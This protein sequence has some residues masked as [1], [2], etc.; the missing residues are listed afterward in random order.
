MYRRGVLS[1]VLHGI[2]RTCIYNLYHKDCSRLG[3]ELISSNKY[4][5]D[6]VG[7][8]RACNVIFQT[9][10]RAVFKFPRDEVHV[11]VR[12]SSSCLIVLASPD[13]AGDGLGRGRAV[14]R[15]GVR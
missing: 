5:C 4:T 3:L 14:S 8:L 13:S 15:P 9:R 12:C 7:V 10:F 11:S 1:C 2:V 6:Y